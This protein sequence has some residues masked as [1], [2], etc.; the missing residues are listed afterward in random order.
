MVSFTTNVT[1]VSNNRGLGSPKVQHLD[2]SEE[3]SGQRLDNFLLSHIKGVPKTRI[4]KSIRKG[5]VR[6]NMKRVKPEYRIQ[7]GD[8]LRIPPL[9]QSQ[10]DLDKE[11]IYIPAKVERSLLDHILYEDEDLI[12]INKP[13]GLA[14]H[15]GSGLSFGVI[16][17]IRL[18]KPELK[19]L[20][21]VHRLDRETSGCLLIAKRR[22]ALRFVHEQLQN[23]QIEKYYHALVKGHWSA[24]KVIDVPLLKN[25]LSSGERI[26]RVD[27]A[28]K[29]CRT[30][31]KVVEIFSTFD[32]HDS[33]GSNDSHR[34][35]DLHDLQGSNDS[36]G[37]YGS[38]RSHDSYSHDSLQN[39]DASL[40]EIHLI[41]GRTHQIR[42]HCL[43]A[44]HPVA[45]D[46]KYGDNEFNQSMKKFGLNRLFLHASRMKLRLPKNGKLIEFEAPMEQ[47]LTSC[48]VEL[49][50]NKSR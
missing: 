44:G 35:S 11:S 23:N 12:A 21:L 37:S 50:R 18:L 33:Q 26:V 42:V 29:P 39:L 46:S 2:I 15:G 25:Q 16:E 9:R 38:H 48:L 49:R 22:S 13:A 28:G 3:M 24:G 5:E 1:K 10:S 30:E 34:S 19:N 8:S 14:V 43:H 7:D 17:A 40:M 31:F 32:S 45:L 20:E 36:H 6:I 41:T 4:Y 27:A 47:A